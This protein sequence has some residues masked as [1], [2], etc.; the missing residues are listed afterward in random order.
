ME[1]KFEF[2]PEVREEIKKML[3][4]EQLANVNGGSGDSNAQVVLCPKDNSRMKY[5][6]SS[7]TFTCFYGHTWF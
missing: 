6:P 5:D 4:E 7:G 1:E 3:D 2:S